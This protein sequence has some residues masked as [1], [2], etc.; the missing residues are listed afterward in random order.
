M[1]IHDVTE[2]LALVFVVVYQSTVARVF[3]S[4]FSRACLR[5]IG[6]ILPF[7]SLATVKD[8]PVD[9]L[10][11]GWDLEGGGNNARPLLLIQ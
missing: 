5:L 4:G 3:R 8:L 6:D 2:Q 10:P 9:F 1:G 11:A 7:Q